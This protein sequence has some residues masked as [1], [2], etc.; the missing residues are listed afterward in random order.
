MSEQKIELVKP[1]LIK[2]LPYNVTRIGAEEDLML[3]QEMRGAEDKTIYKVDPILI[4]RMTPEEIQEAKE[5]WP[6]A[7]YE[8]CDGH[9]RWTAA[10]ELHWSQIRVIVV[11]VT[12][13]EALDINYAKNKIRGQ[14]DPMMEA[15]YFKRLREDRKMTEQ[16][17]ADK[18]GMTHGRVSQILS[19]AEISR[20]ARQIV[21]RV[22]ISDRPSGK[23][24]EAIASLKEPEKQKQLAEIVVK[25]KLSRTETEKARD[26]LQQGL[27][28]EQAVEV[29]KKPE[30]KPPQTLACPACGVALKFIEGKLVKK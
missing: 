24:L 25:E 7:Q 12:H 16:Q 1:Q 26:A 4:R 10:M 19:R 23:H 18:F 13:E 11:D 30:P 15:L 29:A 27:S 22:N 3:H 17:I 14:V 28:Q 20:E 5:K 9:S 21:T 2:P 6:W 8:I